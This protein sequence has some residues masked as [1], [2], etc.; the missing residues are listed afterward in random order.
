MLVNPGTGEVNRLEKQMTGY[1]SNFAVR[2]REAGRA[3]ETSVKATLCVV[4]S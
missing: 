4:G 2:F 1:T 3:N